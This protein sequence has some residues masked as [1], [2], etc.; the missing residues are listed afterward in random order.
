MTFWI[1]DRRATEELLD[2]A[3]P[4]GEAAASLRDIE[5]VH[6]RLGGRR[7]LRRGLLPVLRALGSEPATVVDLGCGNGHVARDLEAMPRPRAAPLRVLGLDRQIAHAA[8]SRRGSA[9]AAD[10]F[11]LP[12]RDGAVDVVLS[13]LF[14]HHL[15]AAGVRAV[16]LES[17]RVAGR[18]VVALDLARHR[19]P[20]ALVSLL[21][22]LVFESRVSVHDGAASVR[23]AFTPAEIAALARDILPGATVSPAGAFVWCLRWTR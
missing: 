9:L 6:R 18:A 13:T 7:S 2:G 1:P 14:L 3:L 11:R 19:L 4:P 10:A 21:G 5:W 8:L 22:P 23:Q 12:F 20:L 15:D 16:L 17:R